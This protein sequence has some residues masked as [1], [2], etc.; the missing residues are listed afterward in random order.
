ME[1]LR[2]WREAQNISAKEAGDLIGVSRVQWFRLER[3]SRRASPDSA[4][5]IEEVTGIPRHEL[6]PDIWTSMDA[7]TSRP[8][9]GVNA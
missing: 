6:R 4:R 5:R 2:E 8:E 1:K 9:A 3:G 7:T